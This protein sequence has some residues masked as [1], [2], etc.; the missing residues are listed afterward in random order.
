M[1]RHRNATV[2]ALLGLSLTFAFQGPGAASAVPAPVPA[3]FSAGIA[4]EAGIELPRP[5]GRHPV[6]TQTLHLTD[7]RR[8]DPWMPSAAREFM[9]SVHYPAQAGRGRSAAYM[10]EE[11]ARLLLESRGLDGVA[12]ATALS[13]TR[14]HARV[15]A[16]PAGGR[17]PLVVLSPGFSVSRS[18]LT[19]LSEDLASRGYVVAAVDH[20]YESVGTAFPGGRVLTCLA[21]DH[22]ATREERARVALGRAQDLSFVI[23]RLTSPLTPRRT[24]QGHRSLSYA[25]MIDSRRIGAAGHSIGGASAAT[26]MAQDRRVRAGVNLDGNFFARL[27]ET[28]LDARPF[29]MMGP[30]ADHDPDDTKS[31]WQEAWA[32][33]DGWK[34]WLTVSG[35]EHFSFTDLL[36]LA[37]QLGLTDP[38]APLSAERAWQHTRD[39]TAAFFDMHLRGMSRPLLDGPVPDRPEV[40]FQPR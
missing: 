16:R 15:N 30:A 4:G 33:L 6:G 9:V 27:P 31:D 36:F 19:A 20:A 37:E 40:E 29:M 1:N 39:Y 2:S 10:T 18:S 13:G 8:S 23:D 25:L 26:L 22:V 35:A 28:G 32:R 14:T 5:T 38:A 12:P 34:R 24:T 17:F 11:E 7:H 21:C 3:A